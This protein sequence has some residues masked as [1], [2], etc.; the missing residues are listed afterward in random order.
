MTYM[1]GLSG[2]V[3]VD[4]GAG[5]RHPYL[6]GSWGKQHTEKEDFTTYGAG[7]GLFMG[8]FLWGRA[9][10]L[11]LRYRGDDRRRSGDSGRWEVGMGLGIF[12]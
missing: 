8:Q 10:Q 12:K 4:L 6:I 1:K 7:L 5:E 9:G 11:E 2:L 3:R